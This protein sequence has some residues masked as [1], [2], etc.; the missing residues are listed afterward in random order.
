ML[1]SLPACLELWTVLWGCLE[2]LFGLPVQERLEAM[3]H[4]WAGLLTYFP[5]CAIGWAPQL[6]PI[7]SQAPCL[8]RAGA[9]DQ[10]LDRVA[11]LP[12]SPG[13]VIRW[14]P[15]ES[16]LAEDPNQVD[17]QPSS[18]ATWVHWL[19]SVDGWALCM[20]AIVNRKT[21]CHDPHTG[22]CEPHP[23]FLSSRF[24]VVR[25]HW[26]PQWSLWSKTELRLPEII[27]ECL[28]VGCPPRALLFPLE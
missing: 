18:L 7:F 22:C 26:F 14:I 17:C 10:Q 24:P 27:Q 28:E 13:K 8:S 6:P 20:G 15:W 19:G 5:E 4:I 3:L 1:A 25:L 12:P 2:L 9:C 21:V 23:L 11:G 16:L